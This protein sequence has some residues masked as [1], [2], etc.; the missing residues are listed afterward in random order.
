MFVIFLIIVGLIVVLI[1]NILLSEEE[2]K[3]VHPLSDYQKMIFL[4]DFNKVFKI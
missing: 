1:A 3:T 2:N 4:F